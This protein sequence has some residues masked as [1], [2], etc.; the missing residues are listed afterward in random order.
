MNVSLGVTRVGERTGEQRNNKKRLDFLTL[1]AVAVGSWEN[2]KKE[3][4]MSLA[5][6]E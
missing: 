3:V 4:K 2:E 1:N 5:V 6:L